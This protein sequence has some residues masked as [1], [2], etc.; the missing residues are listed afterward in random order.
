MI[1]FE[2][3]RYGLMN[4]SVIYLDSGSSMGIGY[5]AIQ[6]RLIIPKNKPCFSGRGGLLRL[7]WWFEPVMKQI[8][9]CWTLPQFAPRVSQLKTMMV[10][11]NTC[12]VC[13]SLDPLPRTTWSASSNSS[14]LKGP[15]QAEISSSTRKRCDEFNSQNIVVY[16]V[17]DILPD[18]FSHMEMDPKWKETNIIN[19]GGSHVPLNHDY[20]RKGI[21][22]SYVVKRTIGCTPPNCTHGIYCVL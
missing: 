10:L 2:W 4:H 20:G 3:F 12:V 8:L 18:P 19:I 9:P 15:S 6:C 14:H 17:D 7:S 11:R 21:P 1:G 5:P 22:N 13:G 16:S